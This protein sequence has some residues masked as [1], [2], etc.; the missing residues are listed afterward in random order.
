MRDC[1]QIQMCRIGFDVSMKLGI[2]YDITSSFSYTT[3][4]KRYLCN[5]HFAIEAELDLPF[6]GGYLV[7]SKLHWF[8]N[9]RLQ[10]N[11]W[12]DRLADRVAPQAFNN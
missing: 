1:C 9:I 3:K 8:K 5:S 6:C 10:L 12:V 11:R 4:R 2:K 7:V